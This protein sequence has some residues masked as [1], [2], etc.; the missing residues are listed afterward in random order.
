VPTPRKR[1][2]KANG[3]GGNDPEHDGAKIAKDAKI[4]DDNALFSMS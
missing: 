3:D 2:T 1:K 4:N